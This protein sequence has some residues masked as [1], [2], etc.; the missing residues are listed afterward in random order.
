MIPG[1]CETVPTD[2]WFSWVKFQCP[3]ARYSKC[4]IQE[5]L[6]FRIIPEGRCCRRGL[7]S[8]SH[9][10]PMGLGSL[11]SVSLEDDRDWMFTKGTAELVEY[12]VMILDIYSCDSFALCDDSTCLRPWSPSQKTCFFH[13]GLNRWWC[14]LPFPGDKLFLRTYFEWQLGQSCLTISPI[15]LAILR[16]VHLNFGPPDL[17]VDGWEVERILGGQKF[18]AEK[19]ANFLKLIFFQKWRR[20]MIFCA[21]FLGLGDLNEQLQI[22]YRESCFVSSV[23]PPLPQWRVRPFCNCGCSQRVPFCIFGWMCVTY[24]CPKNW[25]VEGLWLKKYN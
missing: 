10:W 25:V 20:N 21:H 13:L 8:L 6:G 19:N 11:I 16:P 7:P 5:I 22:W 17:A 18:I 14:H 24:W 9:H 12:L 23:R 1:L 2:T 3:G 4:R 15:G